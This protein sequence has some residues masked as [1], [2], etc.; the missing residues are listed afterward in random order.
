MKRDGLPLA[1]S[2][3]VVAVTAQSDC[4]TE[5]G[6]KCHPVCSRHHSIPVA[7][8]KEQGSQG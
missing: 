7:R 1:S 6:Q 4:A 2:A 5:T 3:R 8:E